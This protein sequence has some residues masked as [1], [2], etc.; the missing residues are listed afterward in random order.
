MSEPINGAITM[1]NPISERL[2]TVADLC[3]YL[4]LSESVIRR[5][6]AK[7]E[8]PYIQIGGAIRFSKTDIDAALE[9][10]KSHGNGINGGN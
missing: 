2:W 1:S 9:A 10:K 7:G 6:K 5:M 3:K 4:A 8:L